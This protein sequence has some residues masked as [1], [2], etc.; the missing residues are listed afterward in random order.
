M[1][2]TS[3]ATTATTEN[4][5]TK[6]KWQQLLESPKGSLEFNPNQSFA[7]QVYWVVRSPTAAKE[8]IEKGFQPC[9]KATFRDTPTTLAYIF[10]ISQD[11]RLAK[12]LKSEV[13]TIGQHPHY[14]PS[15]K[16]IKM[17]IPQLSVETKLKYGGIDTT[18]LSW[19]SEE[20][21]NGHELEL[22]FDPV[23]LECTEIYLD[24]QSFY[25]HAASQ[26]WMKSY[27]EIM[28]A[29]RSLKPKTYCIG[30]PTDDVWEKALESSLKAIRVNEKEIKFGSE[31]QPGVFFDNNLGNINEMKNESECDTI[32]FIEIDLK[33]KKENIK[34]CRS[35]ITLI[36]TELKAPYMVV[37]PTNL[38]DEVEEKELDYFDIRLM[39]S[40]P[41]V[42]DLKSSSL[43]QL[44]KGCEHFEGRIIV[45]EEGELNQGEKSA[46]QFVTL[47][48]LMDNQI[49]V[50]RSNNCE[51][52]NIL[53]GYSLHP[54]FN[55]LVSNDQFNYQV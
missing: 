15:F 38:D 13:K 18:P 5:K 1:L 14:Q 45:F 55:R 29:S 23:V 40:C 19:G 26:D 11:Q 37:L 39:L 28:K 41:Y 54:L 44:S 12:K 20:P 49:S 50:L 10:R 46:E 42:A 22:D 24:N 3:T 25:Q 48:G 52:E 8:M 16:S 51:K 9:S 21:I 47:S 53:A 4:V 6:T 43:G 34:T 30:N 32:F 7:L 35:L 36:Q 31:I 27:S 2:N 33:I 17:G